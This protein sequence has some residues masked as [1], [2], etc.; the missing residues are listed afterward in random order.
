MALDTTNLKKIYY[1]ITEAV[2][3]INKKSKQKITE[4]HI[5]Q[6]ARAY[7]IVLF[8]PISIEYGLFDIDIIISFN[9]LEAFD[10]LVK[11]KPFEFSF[12]NGHAIN[13]YP[14]LFRKSYV[15]LD[16]E[17]LKVVYRM[18][19]FNG[20]LALNLGYIYCLGDLKY[21]NEN[22][23]KL[24]SYIGNAIFC[25]EFLID[26]KDYYSDVNHAVAHIIEKD[27]NKKRDHFLEIPMTSLVMTNEQLNDYTVEI[28]SLSSS[29]NSS[30]DRKIT[31]QGWERA[32]N[33]ILLKEHYATYLES[34]SS[35]NLANHLNFLA[36]KHGIQTLFDDSTIS[37]FI[38]KINSN[39]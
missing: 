11:S 6:A 38:K 1:T 10:S 4:D 34:S 9:N 18:T 39:K 35:T 36:E 19:T 21:S 30:H 3:L 12:G 13:M 16:R 17:K 33:E 23:I 14:K 8:T 22:L 2:E 5:L 15:E 32:L 28:E 31:I 37:R 20:L 27:K 29:E 24:P 25:E 26:G 7:K